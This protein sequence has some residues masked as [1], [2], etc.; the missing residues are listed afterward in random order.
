MDRPRIHVLIPA[1]N[2]EASIAATLESVAAQQ[3]PADNVLVIADNCTDNTAL[4]AEQHG[5]TV[6]AT[7]NNTGKKAGALNQALAQ[8]L[9]G[10]D[11]NDIIL[12]LD[13]DSAIAPEFLAI[14]RAE[15]AKPEVGAVGGVFYGKGG[16]GLIGALQ[17]AEY[18]RYARQIARNGSHAYVLTGTATA[19][20]AKVLGQIA[21]RRKDGSLPP[22][23]GVYYDERTMTEDSY[24]TFAIKTLG[25]Q[26][27]SP[28]ECWVSTEVMPTWRMLWR[29]R[30]R[31]QLGA[32]EDLK[33]FGPLTRVT[34][35]YT[36]KQ[37]VSAAELVWFAA[38]AATAV[39]GSLNGQY[40]VLP[41]WIAIGAIFW[42]ERIVSVRK[43]GLKA[44]LMASIMLIELGYSF[45][46][47]AVNLYSYLKLLRNREISWS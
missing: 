7:K 41:F 5:A 4:V 10:M 9:P 19:F 37:V 24:M 38:Y 3:L 39:W 29:Q 13:A 14:A 42:L 36:A 6:V 26:T 2:E 46:L 21:A 33:A 1:H 22:G 27:P 20:S 47:K 43:G 17:R 32:L 8:V 40:R 35:T 15:L 31:W 18:V 34:W 23:P 30:R 25:Y 16:N 45:F 12:V 44:T 11:D 28:A